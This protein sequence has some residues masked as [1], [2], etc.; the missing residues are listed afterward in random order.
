[1]NFQKKWKKNS[2]SVFYQNK[3]NNI[4]EIDKNSIAFLR[5][6]KNLINKKS[7]VCTHLNSSNKIHEMIIFHKKGAY[8]RPHKHLNRFES[9]NLIFGEIDIILFNYMGNPIKKITMGTYSTGKIFYYKMQKPFFHTLIIK[10]DSLFHE[11]TSGP[12]NPKDT[13][14]AKWSPD[15]SNKKEISKYLKKLVIIS[16]ELNL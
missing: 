10:S 8:V 7:R 5:D 13:L 14:K 9:F 15:E 16:K 3:K 1:M 6:K 11:I 12:F 4:L 2:A